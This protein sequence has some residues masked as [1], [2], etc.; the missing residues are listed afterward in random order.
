ML[1][2]LSDEADL[3]KKVAAETEVS[4]D[5]L[6]D[7][8]YVEGGELHLK[9]RGKD[10]GDSKRAATSNVAALLSGVVFSGTSHTK[11]PFKD[12]NSVCKAKHVH[13]SRNSATYIK[14]TPGF[15]RWA[16]EVTRL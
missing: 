13:D 7:V 3:F 1:V 14:S 9:V 10:L 5:A 6:A 11:V 16:P 4:V 12:I 15:A 2:G 8:F